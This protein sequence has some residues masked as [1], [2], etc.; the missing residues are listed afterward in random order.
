MR[1]VSKALELLDYFTR[2]QPLIG[3]SD[4]AR[5][6]NLNKANC[7]RL[8]TELADSGLVEQIGTGREYRLGPTVLRLAALRAVS[9]TH[10]DVYKRQV[11]THPKNRQFK[12]V[13]VDQIGQTV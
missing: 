6:A 5:Q 1:T 13:F 8:L 11:I 7:F 9:Y 12:T 4:L 3:L 10:L 2:S